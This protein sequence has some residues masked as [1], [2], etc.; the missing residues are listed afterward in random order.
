[1]NPYEQEQRRKLW[2]AWTNTF[3]EISEGKS[4]L[5]IDES[6]L[7]LMRASLRD[8]PL[9]DALLANMVHKKEQRPAMREL[10]AVLSENEDVPSLTMLGA[11]QFLDDDMSDSLN[12]V[13]KALDSEDY[14]LARLLSNGL[15]MEVP[16]G[17]LSR[18]FGSFTSE[19]LMNV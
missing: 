1:M 14:S 8:I 9:R 17:V 3:A 18:S 15:K 4:A 12:T 10:F 5:E 7:E 13:L 2:S 16:S 19:E 6:H 11:I